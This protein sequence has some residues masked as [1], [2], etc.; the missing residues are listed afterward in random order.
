[1][2]VT[3]KCKARGAPPLKYTWTCDG[4]GLRLPDSRTVQLKVHGSGQY[5]CRV[6]N[7]F[8][9]CTSNDPLQLVHGKSY[10]ILYFKKTTL[11]V[12]SFPC[13]PAHSFCRL[14]GNKATLV[15]GSIL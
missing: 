14:S 3:L 2:D 12:V 10:N 7:E 9:S 11:V 15:A 5:N 6:E 4:E 13:R 8:G 1:M